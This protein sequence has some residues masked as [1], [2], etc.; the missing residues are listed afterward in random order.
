MFQMRE[1]QI[2]SNKKQ[3]SQIILKQ[4]TPNE[5]FIRV[6]FIYRING[7][8]IFSACLFCLFF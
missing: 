7:K 3:F 2:P 5:I 8:F 6:F 4:N 1:V